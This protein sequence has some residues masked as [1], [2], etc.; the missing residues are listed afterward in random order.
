MDVSREAILDMVKNSP[1][2]NLQVLR[3][4][5]RGAPEKEIIKLK[6]E[7]DEAINAVKAKA[8]EGGLKDVIKYNDSAKVLDER[9]DNITEKIFNYNQAIPVASLTS[10]QADLT[11]L[12]KLNPGN[13][14]LY[15]DLLKKFN[16]ITGDI[17]NVL[18]ELLYQRVIDLQVT[19]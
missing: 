16:N 2:N 13:T 7:A 1:I 17:I 4:G 9:L 10:V 14:R 8:G 5:V 6:R 3:L 19:I 18:R 15:S 11:D 12:A